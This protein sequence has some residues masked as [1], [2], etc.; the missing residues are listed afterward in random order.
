MSKKTGE[1]RAQVRGQAFVFPNAP[2]LIPRL[3]GRLVHGLMFHLFRRWR[4][5]TLTLETIEGRPILV[6][7]DVFNPK[8]FLTT[9]LLIRALEHTG[10]RPG[11]R[12]LELG[13]GS[14]AIGV[15]AARLGATVIAADINP[16]AVRCARI[17]ALLNGVEDLMEARAS[18][19]FD[20][21]AGETFDVVLFN[22]PFFPGPQKDPFTTAWCFGDLPGRFASELGRHLKPGG[23]AVL[24]L[25]TNGACRE[26]SDALQARGFVLETIYWK[27]L[28]MEYILVCRAWY[29]DKGRI[30]APEVSGAGTTSAR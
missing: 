22:P 5:G 13:T 27:S 30:A 8:I 9:P 18:N 17:N 10:L 12:V 14:G 29:E 23:S 3:M 15:A 2:P 1:Q 19:L 21:L 6:L 4:L 16:A 11:V 28:G 25:S 7:P 20:G 24:L 26:Y